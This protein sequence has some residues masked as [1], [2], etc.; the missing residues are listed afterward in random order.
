MSSGS[1]DDCDYGLERPNAAKDSVILCTVLKEEILDSSLGT[2]LFEVALHDST[3]ASS[4]T[5]S[6]SLATLHPADALDQEPN[7]GDKYQPAPM[8]LTR[9]QGIDDTR[10]PLTTGHRKPSQ[11]AVTGPEKKRSKSVR[12][13]VDHYTSNEDR[14][15]ASLDAKHV[16]FQKMLGK[17]KKKDSASQPPL[18]STK[19]S[20]YAAGLG[21]EAALPQAS[22]IKTLTRVPLSTTPER[23]VQKRL[24]ASDTAMLYYANGPRRSQAESSEGSGIA[25]VGSVALSTTRERRDL[26]ASDSA[27]PNYRSNG[28]R[29]RQAESSEDSGIADVGIAKGHN[30]NPKAREFLSFVPGPEKAVEQHTLDPLLL[31]S[32]GNQDS[33][34]G[35]ISG[36]GAW[37]APQPAN[38]AAPFQ[39]M[40]LIYVM[41]PFSLEP[42]GALGQHQTPQIPPWLGASSNGPGLAANIAANFPPRLDDC[43]YPKGPQPTPIWSGGGNGQAQPIGPLCPMPP[44]QMEQFPTPA[45]QMGPPMG[46]PARPLPVPKPKL[47][48]AGGQQA[49][50]AYIEQRKAMEPGYAIECRLR[51]Q[52]R[53]KRP[54][55]HPVA[56]F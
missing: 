49:Y 37:T 41:P 12:G 13:T 27:L 22:F 2:R 44:T 32:E 9:K 45:V 17:L 11:A 35:V 43:L 54:P 50:E 34:K 39:Q 8:Y 51:Q 4:V 20:G 47:P 24:T 21:S 56:C 25:D 30:L 23:R 42:M 18:R 15:R 40:P 31:A 28:P 55:N 52:R 16:A 6:P 26:T 5:W 3:Q 19:D 38:C 36:V 1:Y 53:A 14:Q 46:L 33:S 7:L 48:N 29:R 10:V